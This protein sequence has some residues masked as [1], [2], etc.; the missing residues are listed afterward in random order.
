MVRH[1]AIV[2][3]AGLNGLTA[4]AHLARAGLKVLVLDRNGRAGGTAAMRAVEPGFFLPAW[5]LR[6]AAIDPATYA[7]LGLADAGLRVR[8]VDAGVSWI[9]PDEWTASFS[10]GTAQRAEFA[11]HAHE[12]GDAWRRYRRD[13]LRLAEVVT[14]ALATA[15]P[16]PGEAGLS[17]FGRR[18]GFASELAAWPRTDMAAKLDIWTESISTILDR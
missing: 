7:D 5:S 11:R 16:Q 14:P 4:A 12:D 10:A 8:A 9:G 6:G 2:I 18:L 15:F 1:D 13:M 17:A 3:G